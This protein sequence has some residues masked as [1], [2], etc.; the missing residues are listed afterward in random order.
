[1]KKQHAETYQKARQTI[2]SGQA[3][4]PSLLHDL[5]AIADNV[6]D[7]YWPEYLETLE[8]AREMVQ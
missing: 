8:K 3:I 7:E 5:E 6:P 4:D 1:M 2:K